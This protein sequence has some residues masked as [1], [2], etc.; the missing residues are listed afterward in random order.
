MTG[1]LE[2]YVFR[3]VLFSFSVS[4]LF[5][6]LVFFLNQIL[7]MGEQILSK[8]APF[9]DVLLLMIFS[10]PAVIALAAPFAALVGVLLAM[11]RLSGEREVLA[12]QACGVPPARLLFPNILLGL[13]FTLLSFGANDVLLPIGTL[14]F[15]KVYRHVLLSTPELELG[16]YA[17]K[18]YKNALIVTGA[19]DAHG[20]HSLLILDKDASNNSRL[21]AAQ[22]GQV[23]EDPGKPGVLTIHL[24]NVTGIV[25]DEHNDAEFST[26]QAR[27]LDYNIILQEMTGA[28]PTIGPREMSSVDLAAKI[29]QRDLHMKTLLQQDQN[30]LRRV[31]DEIVQT[32]WQSGDTD[33]ETKLNGLWNTQQIDRE[34][35]RED[36]QDKTLQN[37]KTE[38]YQKFSIPLACLCFIFLGFPLA[39]Y[40]L[41]RGITAVL[42]AGLFVAILYWASLL[43]ARYVSLELN[44]WPELALFLPNL[45]IL[46]GGAFMLA[47]MRS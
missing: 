27:S 21:L 44:W 20:V 3:E 4:F 8:K 1:R 43:G 5:F 47:R 19:V 14:N 10:L 15:G 37:W 31:N 16:A 9:Q 17:V 28:L 13:L 12:A 11:G 40:Q 18:A 26:F 39:L 7:L 32:Y 6:F 30:E 22:Q 29:H 36:R 24:Q 41:N 33:V 46:A 23:R 2:R 35:V 45:L 42:G 34:K 25:P 38:F